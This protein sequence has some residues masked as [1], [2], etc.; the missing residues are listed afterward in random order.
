MK[1]YILT[2]APSAGKTTL[3]RA[4]VGHGYSVVQEAATDI[5]ALKQAQGIQEPWQ[6]PS[7]VDD[8]V[9]LQKKR[10]IKAV[11]GTVQFHDRSAICC[12]AL[13]KYLGHSPS[14]ALL[15]EIE[16]L[17]RENIFQ[18]EV[19]FIENLGFCKPTAAR[20]ISFEDSLVFEKFHIDAYLHFGY[21]LIEI[22]KG[23]VRSRID[24]IL[25]F[26]S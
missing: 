11:S 25:G 14:S 10:Q 23:S 7:F 12:Y 18:R 5:I 15:K 6:S 16:R 3:I 1:R 4:L 24:E 2:G 22:G 26:I 20:K 17:E 8:I 9:S 21:K 13:S 19:F